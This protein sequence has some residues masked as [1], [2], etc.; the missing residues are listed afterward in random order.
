MPSTSPA[1]RDG[2]FTG[3][4][5]EDRDDKHQITWIQTLRNS[6]PNGDGVRAHVERLKLARA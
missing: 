5:Y 3:A 6:Q 2:S 1:D 4:V